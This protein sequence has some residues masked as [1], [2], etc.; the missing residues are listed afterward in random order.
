MYRLHTPFGLLRPVPRIE[1][2]GDLHRA[3]DGEAQ[4]RL[5]RVRRVVEVPGGEYAAAIV[6]LQ[7]ERCAIGPPRASG[8]R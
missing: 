3:D 6:R 1:L 2:G 8:L 5:G 7:A 4:K